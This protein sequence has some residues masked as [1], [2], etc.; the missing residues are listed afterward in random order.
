MENNLKDIPEIKRADFPED[1][2]GRDVENGNTARSERPPNLFNR[3]MELLLQLGLG[4]S[5]LR[6]ATNALFLIA[7]IGII[8]LMQGFYKDAP[9]RATGESVLAAEPVSTSA[10][11]LEA[12]FFSVNIDARGISRMA[13]M[14]TTIPSRSRLE[15]TTYAVQDGD[16]VFGISEEFGLTPQTILWGNYNTLLDDPHNLKAG[17]DLNILPVNGTYYEWQDGDGLNGVADFFGVDPDDIVNYPGNRLNLETIG[18][19]AR[20][21]IPPGTWLIVPGGE[22]L[23]ISWSAPIGVTREDPASSYILGDGACEPITGGAIGFG[24]FV[25]PAANHYLSGYDWSPKTNHRGIDI[26]GH[27]GAGIFAVDAGVIVYS[28]WNNYGYGNVVMIDHGTGFQSMY[29]HLSAIYVGCGQSVGQ[30]EAIGAFGS[31]GRSSGAHLHFELMTSVY[32]KVN[33]WDFLPLP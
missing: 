27:E 8:L 18:D 25:W 16:T 20:P 5:A 24:T 7:V 26:A 3:W 21:N 2:S 13:E 9:N 19:Y 14:H 10:V 1:M 4:E 12:E 28:G 30:G 33:P 17:Q 23:F 31:T 15:I 11:E 29:A 32:G 22:R 6:V